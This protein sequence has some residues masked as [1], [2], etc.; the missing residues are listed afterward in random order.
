MV[1][2]KKKVYIE[3]RV[4]YEVK[5]LEDNV[6]KLNKSL[7]GLKQV[8]RAQYSCIDGYF[9]KN[10]FVKCLYKYAIYVKIK[11][12]GDTLII[13]MYVDDLIF[14]GNNSKIVGDFKQA[15]IK[16]FEMMNISFMSY[17]LEIEIKQ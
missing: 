16:K 2:L 15:M 4:R 13:C 3:Q 14:T 8:P 12:S 7:Y 5:G 9:L 1:F 10:R 6:L 11:E 17:Y